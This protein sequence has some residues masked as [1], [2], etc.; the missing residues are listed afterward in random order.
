MMEDALKHVIGSTT[1]L[2]AP[3]A[4]RFV[5]GRV[6]NVTS[7]G[8]TFTVPDWDKGKHVFGPAPLAGA[9]VPTGAHIHDPDPDPKITLP[10][11][12]GHTHLGGPIGE[13]EF[14]T[15]TS[16]SHTHG[17]EH[18][19]LVPIPRPGYRCLVLLL[20]SGVDRPWIVGWWPA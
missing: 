19:H 20:G 15:E 10:L 1:Q 6:K 9:A 2:A 14:D 7:A 11:G 16:G 4:Q 5:E 18:R 17:V 3:P 13:V 8:V 12:D